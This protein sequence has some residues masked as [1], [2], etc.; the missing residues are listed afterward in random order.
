MTNKQIQTTARELES[1]LSVFFG[2][3]AYVTC[4][5][6][7]WRDRNKTP[8]Q[9]AFDSIKVKLLDNSSKRVEDPK[10]I[11]LNYEVRSEQPSHVFAGFNITRP[12][13][14]CSGS[15]SLPGLLMDCFK[16]DKLVNAHVEFQ[17]PCIWFVINKDGYYYHI[18]IYPKFGHIP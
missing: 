13:E 4:C 17:H 8:A 5:S 14:Q 11:R 3:V 7:Y 9:V 15:I 16:V 12:G 10:I 18:H 2:D 6:N 1:R